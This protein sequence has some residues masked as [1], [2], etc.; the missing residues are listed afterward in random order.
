[1]GWELEIVEKLYKTLSGL[2]AQL[3]IGFAVELTIW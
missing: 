2:V 3:F 1:M